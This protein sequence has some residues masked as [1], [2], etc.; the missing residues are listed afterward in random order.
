MPRTRRSSLRRAPR[1]C[2]RPRRRHHHPRCGRGR[3]C[4]GPADAATAAA[5][6]VAADAAIASGAAPVAA[7][8]SGV[9]HR[10][11]LRRLSAGLNRFF[12]DQL[13]LA[14]AAE[15]GRM[16]ESVDRLLA[17]QTASVSV[18][19]EVEVRAALT[20]APVYTTLAGD[21]VRMVLAALEDRRG[22]PDGPR[23]SEGPVM[24]S[25]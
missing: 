20:D 17:A 7:V 16:G 6:E 18:W 11:L 25:A 8:E 21:R 4:L 23:R 13:L 10:A 1:R 15:P 14:A 22:Y 12:G 9:V 3:L 2:C 24:R 5:P 19:P